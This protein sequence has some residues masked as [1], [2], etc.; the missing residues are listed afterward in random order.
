ME[1]DLDPI[2][3]M[4]FKSII[5]VV[6]EWYQKSLTNPLILVD[7]KK[8]FTE[9]SILAYRLHI[10]EKNSSNFLLLLIN[11]QTFLPYKFQYN[12]DSNCAI[13]MSKNVSKNCNL[14]D[15]D[16]EL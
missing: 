7:F 16:F 9:D 14:T 12:Y 10:K 13:Y 15:E 8:D 3:K 4:G 5:K 6:E 11:K 2:T 1:E